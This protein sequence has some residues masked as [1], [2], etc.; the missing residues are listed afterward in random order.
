MSQNTEMHTRVLLVNQH[1]SSKEKCCRVSTVFILTS[2]RTEIATSASGAK[3]QGLLAENALVQSCQELDFFFRDLKTA[4]HK[5]LCEGCESRHNHRCACSSTR[6]GN[7]VDTIIPV[8]NKNFTR[9]GKQLTTV[10]GADE[11]TKS[12]LH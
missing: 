12:H 11:E 7:T 3:L 9:N 5:V 1:Q 2:R 6:I 10:L 8:C 4:D